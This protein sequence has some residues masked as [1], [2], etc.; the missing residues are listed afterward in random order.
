LIHADILLDRTW[1]GH[2]LR[3]KQGDADIHAANA[4]FAG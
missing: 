4:I 3:R 2:M 1:V